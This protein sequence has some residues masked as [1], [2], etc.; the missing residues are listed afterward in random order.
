VDAVPVIKPSGRESSLTGGIRRP[1]V[2]E[3]ETSPP[4]QLDDRGTLK[5]RCGSGNA[6]DDAREV[7]GKLEV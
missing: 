4:K 5:V 7:K 3:T 2:K 1:S 6:V